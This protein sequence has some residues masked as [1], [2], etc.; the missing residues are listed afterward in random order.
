MQLKWEENEGPK[1]M[2]KTCRI[3]Q[4]YHTQQGN[5]L[6]RVPL[7]RLRAEEHVRVDVLLVSAEGHVAVCG[8][9]SPRAEKR[10]KKRRN[11]EFTSLKY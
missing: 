1:T 11:H 5:R 7:P 8:L 3:F 4:S 10:I 2:P 9:S 6:P